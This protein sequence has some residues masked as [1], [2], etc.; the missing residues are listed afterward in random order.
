MLRRLSTLLCVSLDVL[1]CEVLPFVPTAAEDSSKSSR[2]TGW[3]LQESSDIQVDDFV[4]TL[5]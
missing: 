2:W 1:P 4:Y 5:W 3:C